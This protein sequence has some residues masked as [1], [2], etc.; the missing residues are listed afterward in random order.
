[1]KDLIEKAISGQGVAM[2]LVDING[3]ALSFVP[4]DY[5]QGEHENGEDIA[6]HFLLVLTQWL[7]ENR[8]LPTSDNK[9]MFTREDHDA[10]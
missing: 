10:L 5:E 2:V 6:K 1:M 7:A 9:S 8:Y 4:F 3:Q